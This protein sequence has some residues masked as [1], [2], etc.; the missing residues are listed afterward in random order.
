MACAGRARPGA[1]P[2]AGV[3]A[4]AVTR[5]PPREVATLPRPVV[6]AA[7][8]GP[9]TAGAAVFATPLPRL[10]GAAAFAC[11][12]R[13]LPGAAARACALPR[14]RRVSAFGPPRGAAE[15][16]PCAVL[17]PGLGLTGWP[18]G[19]GYAAAAAQR[20]LPAVL[21][22]AGVPGATGGRVPAGVA[23]AGGAA[24]IAAGR[25]GVV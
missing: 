8:A 24:M 25:G 6:A 12:L 19:A 18:L 22:Q 3:R 23:A 16:R 1:A 10:P 17:R 5:A 11:S 14:F 21:A 15:D 2:L 9:R 20:G 7:R 13:R 4:T